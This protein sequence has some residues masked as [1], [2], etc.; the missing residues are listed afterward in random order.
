MICEHP[1]IAYEI[2][3][4]VALPFRFAIHELKCTLCGITAVVV[5]RE[6]GR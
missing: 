1:T 3:H 4:R 6:R 2:R 5:N